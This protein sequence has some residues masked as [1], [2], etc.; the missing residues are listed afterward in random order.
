MK[1]T[2][3]DFV[4]RMCGDA[5]V[6]GICAS[7]VGE[8][9]GGDV[10]VRL[11]PGEAE[12]LRRS[13]CVATFAEK[14]T[15]VASVATPFVVVGDL[16]YTRRNWYCE[17]N[18]ADRIAAM[19][20][21]ASGGGV[22]LPDTDFYRTLRA[23]QRAAVQ[24]MCGAQFSILTGGPGTG[25]TFTIGRAVRFLQESNP[26]L[27]L[28]LAAPTAAAAAKM[29]GGLK[30]GTA[31][32][33]HSMLG[34]NPEQATVKFNRANPLAFDWVIVDESSMI[35]LS[36]MSKLLDALPKKCRLTL[37]GDEDQLASV[38]RG[39]VF[40]DLCRMRGV[41]IA[42]LRESERFKADGDIAKLAAAVNGGRS[43]EALAILKEGREAVRYTDLSSAR[44]Y[45]PAGWGGFETL[46][47]EKFAAFRA[48]RDAA[49]AL[50]HVN[51]FRVLC[52]VREGPYGVGRMNE[53]AKAL[54]GRECPTPVMVTRNDETLKVWN[55]NVGV[56]MPGDEKNLYLQKDGGGIREVRL[57]LLPETE[58][59]FASTVHKAQG[60]EY[61]DVAM[62]LPVVGEGEHPLL[63]R[64]IL[65]TGITRTKRHVDVFGSDAAVRLCCERQVERVSGMCEE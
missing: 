41:T 16:L 18:V 5:G 8:L 11:R 34:A 45:E 7:A 37:A 57:E 4:F 14:G 23:E 25:K 47:R 39:R 17:R 43:E 1:D 12:A 31:V 61:Q 64:E 48:S 40:G 24:A 65:Y 50:R 10:C 28:G 62:V 35:G 60:S 19:A 46:L 22:E 27:R 42:R 52:A 9:D 53:F 15:A 20:E 59:A 54:L 30:A 49:E 6:A 26:G 29:S 2:V 33:I 38:E 56:V 13:P 55:G 32:T 21:H 51:D 44:A 63:T 36:L 3:R 58:T